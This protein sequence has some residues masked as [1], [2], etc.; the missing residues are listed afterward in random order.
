MLVEACEQTR[1]TKPPPRRHIKAVPDQRSQT[2]ALRKPRTKDPTHT[3][4]DHRRHCGPRDAGLCTDLVLLSQSLKPNLPDG[5][6]NRAVRRMQAS[7]DPALAEAA[8]S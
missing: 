3:L 2:N 7:S 1:S 8:F 4:R 5:G 6:V